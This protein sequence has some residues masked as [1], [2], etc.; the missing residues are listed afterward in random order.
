MM[1]SNGK[2]VKFP[3]SRIRSYKCKHFKWTSW[4]HYGCKM[5]EFGCLLKGGLLGSC[6]GV[7]EKFERK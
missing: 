5:W 3:K 4:N 6:N 2:I 7:C 1:L